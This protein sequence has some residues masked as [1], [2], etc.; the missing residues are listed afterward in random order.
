MNG[1][2]DKSMK[3]YD[4]I[5][6]GSGLFGSV[7][8]RELTDKGF[9][10]LVLEKRAHIGGNIYTE[11]IED[12]NVHKYG[13]HIFHTN[14]KA[15]WDYVNRFA[16]FNNFKN[17]PLA[18]YKDKLFNLPFNMNTFYQ[19]WGVTKPEEAK[20]IIQK[21]IDDYNCANPKNLEEQAINM[22]GKDVYETL[23]KEYTEKQWGR[24]AAQLPAFIIK[25]LPLRFTFDNNYFN[26]KYQGIP[27][28]GY[29]LL[30]EK[31]LEGVTVKL[32]TD[33]LLDKLNWQSKTQKIIYTGPLD[34][35]YEYQYGPL[36]YR[37]L[38]FEN[39]L[40]PID[41]YQGNAVV[42]YIEKSVPYTRII[43][44]KHFEFGT[45]SKTYI[46]KEFP[47]EWE[48]GDEPYY[49]IND[50]RNDN[51]SRAYK[52]LAKEENDVYFGG[53]L[54]E[55]RYY[56]MHQVVASALHLVEKVKQK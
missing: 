15:I 44:H 28:G 23:I 43:E 30:I 13:A 34:A 48:K 26:D 47:K 33:F 11:K 21:Q 42:N 4:Y 7:C 35:F 19:L 55:Y 49:P 14:D 22:V 41:N 8:A 27:I 56:D 45:Q 36:Q 1:H 25:R 6:V 40:L 10:C 29:T 9:K 39:E 24:P 54:A 53:R 12:I 17:S 32:E 18:L 51:L 52:S 20:K 5:I 37:S 2:Y 38:H 16:E 31:L 3:E 50:K 46:S